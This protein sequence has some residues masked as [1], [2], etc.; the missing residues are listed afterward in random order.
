LR[1]TIALVLAAPL[2]LGGCVPLAVG[3]AAAG[4]GYVAGQER[5]IGGLVSDQT[6]KSR[7]ESK[8]Y[9]ANKEMASGLT[10]NVEAGK[11]VVTGTVKDPEWKVDAVRL[12]WQVDGVKE[13]HS[14]AAVRDKTTFTEDTKD[15]WIT[16][17]LRTE[18]IADTRVRSLNYSIETVNGTVYLMGTARTQEELDRVVNHARNLSGVRQVVNYVEIRPGEPRNATAA[19]PRQPAPLVQGGQDAQSGGSMAAPPTYSASPPPASS[20]APQPLTPSTGRSSVEVK[21]L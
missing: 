6:L 1:S 3:G 17:K 21:P 19:Q 8:W 14:E 5:G 18:L 11:V 13:V 12:A 4:A 10:A 7:V 2:L 9:E 20:G 16:T 15:T